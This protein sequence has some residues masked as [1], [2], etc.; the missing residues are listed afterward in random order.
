MR[1]PLTPTA[2]H[3][4]GAAAPHTAPL[5]RPLP[6]VRAHLQHRL[7]G[8]GVVQLLEHLAEE[9]VVAAIAIAIAELQ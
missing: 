6:A 5:V 8:L 7:D 4:R 1:Q 9:A 2:S 3:Y